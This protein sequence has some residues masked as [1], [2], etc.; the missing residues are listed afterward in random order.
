[1]TAILT[2]TFSP[3]IDKSTTVP[4]LVPEKKLKCGE[5]KLEP[6]GGGINV[7]RAICQL[8][9]TATAVFPAGGYTGKAFVKLLQDE[10]VPAVVVETEQETRENIIVYEESSGRQ[11]RFGMP[12]TPLEEGEWQQLLSRVAE[13]DAVDFIVASGSLPPGVPADVFARIAAMA[14]RKKARLIVDT[15]GEALKEAARQGLYL[16]KPNLGELASL[17]G[18]EHLAPDD[19]V[20]AARQLIEE[21]ECEVVVVSRGAD[22]ATLVTKAIVEHIAP[23]QVEQKSTVGAGDSMVAGIVFSLAAGKDLQ[24]A[25]RYGVACGTAA[26]LRAGTELCRR[27]DADRIFRELEIS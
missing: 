22:G 15:S 2:I 8:G 27:E 12:G 26:T 9:A 19:I 3:C 6:G 1:M 17:A 14:K 24:T 5:P 21:Q 16:L 11:F 18:R 23:P 13:A 10:H 25:V 4:K 20:A 7:A